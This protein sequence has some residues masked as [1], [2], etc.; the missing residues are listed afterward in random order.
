MSSPSLRDHIKTIETTAHVVAA[1]WLKSRAALALAD[2]TVLLTDGMEAQT[3]AAHPDAAVLVAGADEARLVTGGDDGRVASCDASGSVTELAA[4]KGRW[5][6]AVASRADGAFAYSI[7][8]DVFVQDG[9]GVEKQ[10]AVP[11]TARGLAFAPKGY[12]I[13]AT[14]Y[15]GVTLWFPNVSG[16]PE[17]FEWKGSHLDVS[18]SPD[19]RFVVTTMQENALHGW[20]IG[21]KHHM[22]MTGYPTKTRSLSWSNDGKWLATSGA[23]AAIVWPFDG[24]DGPMGKP[25]RECGV[26]PS[27]ISRVAFHPK[28]PMLAVGYEDG[29]ILLVRF[30]DAHELL[31]REAVAGST[32]TALAWN[33]S[34]YKLVFGC[35]D[36][37]AGIL[38]LPT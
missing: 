5:I 10:I 6:D 35:S 12:R 20:R 37:Q 31:I 16:E 17:M 7:G 13:A 22:R 34:G 8:R 27:R 4:R 19:N 24:K 14:H 26:R 3:V 33:T 36:G 2:G 1:T 18:F 32:V 21:D 28:S 25:P 15:N 9:K 29:C 38:T 11:T 30:N 23:D